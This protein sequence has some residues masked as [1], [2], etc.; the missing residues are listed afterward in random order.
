MSGRGFTINDV[1]VARRRI[2]EAVPDAE[3]DHSD[4]GFGLGVRRPDAMVAYIV[5]R[6][7]RSDI[8]QTQVIADVDKIIE[9][10]QNG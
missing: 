6:P 2:V 1:E 9:A 8:G 10:L 7:G 5:F 3:F 4:Y